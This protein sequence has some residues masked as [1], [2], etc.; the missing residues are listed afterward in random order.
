MDPI[1]CAG[2]LSAEHALKLA[3]P[4]L[5]DMEI[6]DGYWIG[7]PAVASEVDKGFVPIM[8]ERETECKWSSLPRVRMLTVRKRRA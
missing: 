4:I 6:A 5:Y 8:A 1:P 2:L 7:T 3:A